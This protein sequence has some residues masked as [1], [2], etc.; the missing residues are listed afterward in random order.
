VF[1]LKEWKYDGEATFR[2]ELYKRRNEAGRFSGGPSH[3][4][5]FAPV[6][7]NLLVSFPLAKG[8]KRTG[9]RRAALLNT[10]KE[11]QEAGVVRY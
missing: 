4:E 7:T 6:M 8:N 1:T 9:E 5:G 2:T 10:Q 11:V 3:S